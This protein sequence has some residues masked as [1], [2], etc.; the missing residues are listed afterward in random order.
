MLFTV[1]PLIFA[2]VVADFDAIYGDP[3]NFC[4]SGTGMF[5]ATCMF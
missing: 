1:I 2:V 3:A 5:P 4:S